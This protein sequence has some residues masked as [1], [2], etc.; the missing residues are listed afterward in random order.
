MLTA[1]LLRDFK[2]SKVTAP[3]LE[4]WEHKMTE[5]IEFG[6]TLQQWSV[7]VYLLSVYCQSHKLSQF[8][9]FDPMGQFNG[10][11]QKW[12][13]F[14]IERYQQRKSKIN[15]DLIDNNELTEDDDEDLGLADLLLNNL[16]LDESCENN[17][18][19]LGRNL[20]Y[21]IRSGSKVEYTIAQ[22]RSFCR[23]NAGKTGFYDEHNRLNSLVSLW[24]ETVVQSFVPPKANS[25][26]TSNA[27]SSK[28]VMI[29]AGNDNNS[30]IDDVLAE[31]NRLTSNPLMR[32][33]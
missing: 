26:S 2:I 31:I 15:R 6:L 8:A 24:Y 4:A 30:D 17:L 19:M 7:E 28:D 1:R 11:L 22:V 13:Q 12:R 27:K 9:S 33:E 21:Q 3:T 5:L 32:S 25:K 10:L 16:N 20:R 23:S 14:V 29:N 18:I